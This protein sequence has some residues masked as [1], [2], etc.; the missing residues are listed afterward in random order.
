MLDL[1]DGQTK[2]DWFDFIE[3]RSYF[4]VRYAS[5]KD[6]L[7]FWQAAYWNYCIDLSNG[8]TIWKNAFTNNYDV[9]STGIGD[10]IFGQ[11]YYDKAGNRVKEGGYS[12]VFNTQNGQPYQYIRPRYDTI[13]RAPFELTQSNGIVHF[14]VPLIKGQDTLL[15]LMIQLVIL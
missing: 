5:Q 13:G 1:T 3:E 10:K 12:V 8:K 7:F 9:K 4:S 2:W 15:L 14:T 11:Y 6:N